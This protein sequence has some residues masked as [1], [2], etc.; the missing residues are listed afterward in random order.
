MVLGESSVPLFGSA[1]ANNLYAEV[2]QP[3]NTGESIV[4]DTDIQHHICTQTT[5]YI[6]TTYIVL[7]NAISMVLLPVMANCK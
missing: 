5:Y 3:G 4:T 2:A 7:R 1:S 6:K